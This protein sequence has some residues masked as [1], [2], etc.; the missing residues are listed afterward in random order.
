[1]GGDR[2]PLQVNVT[3]VQDNDV[4]ARTN[5]NAEDVFMVQTKSQGLFA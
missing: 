1:M 4:F 5:K 2:E 3:T